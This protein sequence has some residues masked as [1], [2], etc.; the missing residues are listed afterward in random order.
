MLFSLPCRYIENWSSSYLDKKKKNLK[1]ILPTLII[2]TN[3]YCGVLS[4]TLIPT[5]RDIY[6]QPCTDGLFDILFLK[7]QI[8]HAICH[9][10][11]V[12]TKTVE[13]Q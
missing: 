8:S 1:I 13:F 9:F 6:W 2:L 4:Q 12:V 3:L 10:V 7:T 11:L 5:D